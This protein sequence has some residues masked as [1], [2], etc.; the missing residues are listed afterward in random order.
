MCDS[1][2][3]PCT[4]AWTGVKLEE[5]GDFSIHQLVHKE[6]FGGS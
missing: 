4:K 2:F 1:L 6:H 5:K 3:K